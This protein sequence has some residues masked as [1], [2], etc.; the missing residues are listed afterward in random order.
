MEYNDFNYCPL[1]EKNEDIVDCMENIDIAD[2]F[3]PDRFKVKR[4]WK[5]I[6]N[7]CPIHNELV[8]EDS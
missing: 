5:Q 3:I 1:T 7:N 2:R 4:D 6:C 8:N